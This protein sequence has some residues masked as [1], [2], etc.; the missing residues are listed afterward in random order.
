M[1]NQRGKPVRHEAFTLIEILVVVA[2]IALLVAI[3]LPSLAKARAQGRSAQCLS[4]LHQ[5]VLAMHQYSMDYKGMVPG[6]AAEGEVHWVHYAAK[7]YGIV[8]GIP[9][10]ANPNDLNLPTME[11]F[12]CPERNLDLPYP[13]LGYVINALDPDHLLSKSLSDVWEPRY[14]SNIDTTWRN[15]AEVALI[16][17]AARETEQA[18]VTPAEDM[19]SFARKEWHSHFNGTAPVGTAD[20]VGNFD[21]RL[22]QHLPES[23]PSVGAPSNKIGQPGPRRVSQK[24]HSNQFTNA[25]FVDGH[26]GKMRSVSRPDATDAQLM[27]AFITWLNRF[28]VKN[29]QAATNP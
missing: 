8:K 17:D 25:G 5:H 16:V 6:D 10:D 7:T 3:L 29:A 2:I 28:G 15:P 21:C 22:P 9:K 27:A 11:L 18:N 14:T 4:N 19:L 12:Q 26:A 24:M 20:G 23:P 1:L 13:F